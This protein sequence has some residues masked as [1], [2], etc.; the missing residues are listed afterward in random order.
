MGT[1]TKVS[2]LMSKDVATLQRNDKLS[3]ANNVME[4][5]R[6]RHLPV[7]D[8]DGVLCGVVSQRDLFRVPLVRSFGYG[9]AAQQRVLDT[10]LVKEVMAAEVITAEPDMSLADAAA[11][12]IR[13]KVGCLPVVNGEA[14]VGILTEG[15]FVAYFARE[16]S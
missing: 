7:L 12:M 13:H 4:L 6:I 10:I 9:T 3:I 14:L 11:L 15:D 2:D 5:G 8:E 16:A 1:P